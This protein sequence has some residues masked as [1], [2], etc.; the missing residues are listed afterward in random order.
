[1]AFSGQRQIAFQTGF[2]D[3]LFGRPSDNPYD[4][5]VVGGSYAAYEE[6]YAD[7]LIS[8]TPP[9]G[10]Q[11]ETGDTG[12]AGGTGS[13]GSD[14]TNGVNGTSVHTGN[15][16]PGAGLGNDGD[17]YIDADNGDVYEKITGSW[18]LQGTPGSM[19]LATRTDTIDPDVIPEVTYR[20]DALPGTVTSAALW[21]VQRIT[22]QADRDTVIVFA[23]GDDDFDNIWDNRLSLSYS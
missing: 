5:N 10:P 3:A 8:D 21:R 2:N 20:G 22:I 14:G 16:A 6:G 13:S 9:R 23:D 1:M 18:S 4:I 15:G 7:G 12:P 19:A 17:V 11:G